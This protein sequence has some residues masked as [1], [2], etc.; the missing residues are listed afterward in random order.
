MKSYVPL[1]FL[2]LSGC[3]VVDGHFR[4]VWAPSFIAGACEGEGNTEPIVT[5]SAKR[6]GEPILLPGVRFL[7]VGPISKE[8]LTGATPTLVPN[9]PS[10]EYRVTVILDGFLSARC[11]VRIAGGRCTLQ[12]TLEV[13]RRASSDF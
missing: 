4:P 2:F 11:L 6:I 7:F 8:V 5:I 10:G 1:A 12:A 3:A 9:L 13:T